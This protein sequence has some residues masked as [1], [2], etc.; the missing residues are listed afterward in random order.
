MAFCAPCGEHASACGHRLG[1]LALAGIRC[2]RGFLGVEIHRCEPARRRHGRPSVLL[3]VRGGGLQRHIA[4]QVDGRASLRPVHGAFRRHHRGFADDGERFGVR[5]AFDRADLLTRALRPF[6]AQHRAIGSSV[7]VYGS[8]VRHRD[9]STGSQFH[10]RLVG[11]WIDGF[12]I[13]SGSHPHIAGFDVD[14]RCGITSDN[15]FDIRFDGGVAGFANGGSRDI[16]GF[17]AFGNHGAAIMLGHV[18]TGSCGRDSGVHILVLRIES[19][20]FAVLQ[21]RDPHGAVV[22]LHMPLRHRTDDERACDDTQQQKQH[23]DRRDPPSASRRQQQF[24][25]HRSEAQLTFVRLCRLIGCVLA[26]VHFRF[27]LECSDGRCVR[28][29]HRLRWNNAVDRPCWEVL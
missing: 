17:G 24:A 21:R 6:D 26:F 29:G 16:A 10:V 12:H 14:E 20:G 3:A 8:V 4:L 1:G 13:G 25:H 23:D 7:S 27:F 9:F 11:D 15:G 2:F 28:S 5:G 18:E 19:C 22:K